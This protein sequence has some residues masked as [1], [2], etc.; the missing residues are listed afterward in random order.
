MPYTA[1]RFEQAPMSEFQLLERRMGGF[2]AQSSKETQ[3][4]NDSAV[5]T[6]MQTE[7]ISSQDNAAQAGGDESDL[8]SGGG[9]I[10]TASGPARLKRDFDPIRLGLFLRAAAQVVTGLLAER[11]VA[12]EAAKDRDI[13]IAQGNRSITSGCIPL[14]PAPIGGSRGIKDVTFSQHQQNMLFVAY[15]APEKGDLASSAGGKG[16][17]CIW[18]TANCR[19]PSHILFCESNP[20]RCCFSGHRLSQTVFAATEDGSLVGWDLREPAAMH[21]SHKM[22]NQDVLVLRRPTYSTDGLSTDGLFEEHTGPICS[23]QAIASPTESDDVS[24]QLAVLDENGGLSIWTVVELGSRDLAGSL[25]DFCLG[26]GGK[27]KL[28]KSAYIDLSVS[29]PGRQLWTRTL[30][31]QFRPGDHNHAHVGTG[32]GHILHVVRHGTASYPLQYESYYNDI[33]DVQSVQYSPFLSDYFLTAANDGTVCLYHEDSTKP[34]HAWAGF[35]KERLLCAIWSPSQPQVFFAY[36]AEGSIYVWDMLTNSDE[37]VHTQKLAA[38]SMSNSYNETEDTTLVKVSFSARGVGH[39]FMVTAYANGYVGIHTLS[40]AYSNSTVNDARRL[41]A[42]LTGV[43]CDSL[44]EDPVPIMTSK[45]EPDES[46]P[47]DEAFGFGDMFADMAA[48]AKD[49]RRA[50]AGRRAR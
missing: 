27:V 7:E 23:L 30:S 17:L 44:P 33:C 11:D 35:T 31:I 41:R 39:P 49:G 10:M 20:V 42:F 32:H 9:S 12:K 5:T 8:L 37:P 19:R 3:T 50:Q 13:D 36:T 29:N 22:E 43:S 26:V 25:Q 4:N 6:S 15:C 21:V 48:P 40:G 28:M 45:E 1:N 46:D 24:F 18:D 2:A 14:S 47:F 34:M 16:L 38:G